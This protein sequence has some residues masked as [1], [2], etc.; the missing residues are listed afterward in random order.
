M[1]VSAE[2]TGIP[3]VSHGPGPTKGHQR[4]ESDIFLCFFLFVFFAELV[5]DVRKMFSA[6]YL[7]GPIQALNR[8]GTLGPTVRCGCTY[9]PSSPLS[10]GNT[11]GGSAG[12]STSPFPPVMGPHLLRSEGECG[13]RAPPS[14]CFRVTIS[15][16]S[17]HHW[18]VSKW[19]TREVFW[20]PGP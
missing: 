19:A 20:S 11:W 4:P 14:A 6:P 2:T 8:L 1:K 16:D 13:R 5:T 18:L 3:S 9:L 12:I 15:S 10:A 17:Q 7:G